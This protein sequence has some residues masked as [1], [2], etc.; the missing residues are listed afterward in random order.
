VKVLLVEDDHL[1]REGLAE[2]LRREGYSVVE[3]EDGESAL[4]LCRS[5]APDIVCLDIMMPKV[6]G[7]E[8]C[9]KMRA[10]RSRTPI[11]FISAKSEEI[12][13]VVG[14]EMGADDFIGAD[15]GGDA[16]VLRGGR[17]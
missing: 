10:E 2:I 17:G 6:S 16:A 13:K 12:D 1:I 5:E 8:V 11:I 15:S 7:F 9:R 3:A 4:A 14:L